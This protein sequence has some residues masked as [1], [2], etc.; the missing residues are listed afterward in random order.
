MIRFAYTHGHGRTR[1]RAHSGQPMCRFWLATN[2]NT[3]S[4]PSAQKPRGSETGRAHACKH[5]PVRHKQ[6]LL[7][8]RHLGLKHLGIGHRSNRR[9]KSS[10]PMRQKTRSC[11]CAYPLL[12]TGYRKHRYSLGPYFT[13]GRCP[14]PLRQ[15]RRWQASELISAG[16]RV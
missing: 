3:Q 7:R 5:V 16:L 6:Q 9:V 10:H 14:P 4:T 13:C 11:L 1:T 8:N 12:S 15:T 2:E